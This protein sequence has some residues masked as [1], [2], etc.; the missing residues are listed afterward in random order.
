[1]ASAAP[2]IDGLPFCLRLLFRVPSRILCRTGQVVRGNEATLDALHASASADRCDRLNA[3][4]ARPQ[5]FRRSTNRLRRSASVIKHPMIVPIQ[6][7]DEDFL[8]YG[9]SQE[10]SH[11]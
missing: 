6:G 2:S 7:K 1:M 11:A 9:N 5:H 3:G 8:V 4:P 10:V